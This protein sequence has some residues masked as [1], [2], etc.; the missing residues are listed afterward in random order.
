VN[1]R[2]SVIFRVKVNVKISVKIRPE[3]SIPDPESERQAKQGNDRK[4]E[5]V[6][7]KK[8]TQK[9]EINQGFRK[10]KGLYKSDHQLPRYTINTDSGML[11]SSFTQYRVSCQ[12]KT[13]CHHVTELPPTCHRS[14]LGKL[15]QK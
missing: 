10:H 5:W 6:K 11:V 2:F 15:S 12:P 3:T 8:I 1:V 14:K 4:R 7:L 9:S 13:T